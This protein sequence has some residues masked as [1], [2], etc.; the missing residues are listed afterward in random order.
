MHTRKTAFAFLVLLA[1]TLPIFPVYAETLYDFYNTGDDGFEILDPYRLL[2]QTFTT[3]DDSY[4]ITSVKIKAY[5]L[6]TPGILI[7]SIRNVDGDGKPTGSD[8]TYGTIDGDTFTTNEAG[9]WYEVTFTTGYTLLSNTKYAIVADTPDA[10]R[11]V[12]QVRW[13]GDFSS[14]TYDGGY[15]VTSPDKII[16]IINETE[17]MMFETYGI[18]YPP[19]PSFVPRARHGPPPKPRNYLFSAEFFRNLGIAFLFMLLVFYAYAKK[20]G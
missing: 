11:G 19:P 16:W 17:D 12:T 14:P 8:L 4:S 20:R 2:A 13:R 6:S 7:I 15:V 5:R 18:F 10:I 3:G 9:E 1:L